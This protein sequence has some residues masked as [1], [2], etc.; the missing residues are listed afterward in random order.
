MGVDKSQADVGK[1]QRVKRGKSNP[2]AVVVQRTNRSD[3]VIA[4]VECL[5][6]PSGEGQGGSFKLREWQKRFIRDV[7]D[8]I[9]DNGR[10]DVRRAV[11]SVARKN[12]KTA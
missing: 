6:I 3:Y 1:R 8:P 10:R 12:G 2:I 11:L 7:Y 4:F 9:G 5:T